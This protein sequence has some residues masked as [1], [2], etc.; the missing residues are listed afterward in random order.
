MILW[1]LGSEEAETSER[2]QSERFENGETCESGAR[3]SKEIVEEWLMIVKDNFL[4][5]RM[6]VDYLTQWGASWPMERVCGMD[7]IRMNCGNLWKS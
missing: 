7:G 1:D 3:Y 2:W 5:I 4:V 6:G